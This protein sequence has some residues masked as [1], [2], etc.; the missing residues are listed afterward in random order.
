MKILLAVLVF[1]LTMLLFFLMGAFV[2]NS[3]NIGDWSGDGRFFCVMLGFAAGTIAGVLTYNELK[4][5]FK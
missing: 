1:V 2:G 4:G 3:F 5:V